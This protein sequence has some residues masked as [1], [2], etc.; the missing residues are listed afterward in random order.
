[1]LPTSELSIFAAKVV[2][3]GLLNQQQAEQIEANA[4]TQHTSFYQLAIDQGSVSYDK[5][6]LV[7][8][9]TY[10]LSLIDIRRIKPDE[11]A[12][13]LLPY[14]MI[15][16][17][18]MLPILVRGQRLIVAISEP[19]D[20]TALEQARFHSGR[21]IVPILAHAKYLQRTIERL[22]SRSIGHSPDLSAST[23][24]NTSDADEGANERLDAISIEASDNPIVQ[25]VNKIIKDA[26]AHQASDIHI[27]PYEQ[28]ARIRYRI[29]GILEPAGEPPLKLVRNIASRIKVLAE[30]NIA[31]RRLPQDGRIKL[32]FDHKTVDFRVS[33]LPT[34]FG[35]KVVIRVLDQS[36]VGLSLETIGMSPAQLALYRNAAN[37]PHGMILVTGP[38]GSGKTVSLYAAIAKLNTAER[39]ICSAEDPV[40]I[41]AEGVN[42]V[43]INEKAGL[44]FAVALRTFLRQDPDILMV[45]EIRDLETAEI[46]VKAAQ[47]G[48][49]LLSTLHTNDAAA[50]IVRL[51]NMGVAP[52]NIASTIN[53][54]IAQRLVRKLCTHCRQPAD[55]PESA[56]LDAGFT[57][58]QLPHIDL[59]EPVGCDHCS[60]GYRGRTGIFEVVPISEASSELIMNN[61]NQLEISRQIH[62][63]SILLIKAHG[64]EKA[65]VGITSLEEVE[66]V[67]KQ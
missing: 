25:Y 55:F 65:A 47:T 45:G 53:L 39:N 14:D 64:L 37:Q 57:P 19:S 52:F 63:E 50:T 40:E 10:A 62:S 9:E 42:Q 26:I 15:S 11:K 46:A 58:E 28:R 33:T 44:T 3:A 49:L 43:S 2:T 5:L 4:R 30:L 27:E 35:E 56:L 18:Q 59:Y 21:R 20:K 8:A 41:Y 23:R 67:T 24:A 51:L 16:R 34:I 60:E 17:Y 22:G 7:A 6:N 36:G 38:T 31:E 48:H 54:I 12:V 32:Q 61:A 13:Q 66:R 1:M 29:D